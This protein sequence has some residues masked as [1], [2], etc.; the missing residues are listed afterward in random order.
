MFRRENSALKIPDQSL[1]FAI[2]M[3]NY[4][5]WSKPLRAY[6]DACINPNP[7]G[8]EKPFNMRWIASL[9]AEAQRILTR[10]GVFLYPNDG[11]PGYEG[12]RLRHVYEC[13]PI[14]FLI[15]QAGDWPLTAGFNHGKNSPEFA[16][17]NPICFW[18]QKQ[19]R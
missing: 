19:C 18:L 12:G 15:E 17:Q 14:A 4:H 10:G 6:V 8:S 2:N 5:H 1:E 11:R 7:E 13:G 16:F 9:V 3:S